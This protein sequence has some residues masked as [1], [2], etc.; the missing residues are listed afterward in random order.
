VHG[1]D[2]FSP[3]LLCRFDLAVKAISISRRATVQTTSI[4]ASVGIVRVKC[5]ALFLRAMLV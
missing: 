5:S 2:Y 1:G 3:R 4:D